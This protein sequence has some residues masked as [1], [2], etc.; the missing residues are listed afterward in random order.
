M[1]H[2]SMAGPSMLSMVATSMKPVRTKREYITCLS[3]ADGFWERA[4]ASEDW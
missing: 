3:I 4:V 2:K 1:G